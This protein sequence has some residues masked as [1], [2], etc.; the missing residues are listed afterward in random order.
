MKAKQAAQKLQA[1][2]EDGDTILA[3]INP[4]E[5]AHLKAMGGSG[6]VNPK[7]GLLSFGGYEGEG[8]DF[9]DV[10]F[11]GGDWGDAGLQAGAM[12]QDIAAQNFVNSLMQ[13][14]DEQKATAAQAMLS[15][16]QLGMVNNIAKG[17]GS[18]F[19]GMPGSVVAGSLNPG[20]MLND[21][22]GRE[23]VGTSVDMTAGDSLP[24]GG[25]GYDN[26]NG[27]EPVTAA[28]SPATSAALVDSYA[29][30][31]ALQRPFTNKFGLLRDQLST[32]FT[33][34]TGNGLLSRGGGFFGS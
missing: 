20:Q 33:R 9:G 13:Q 1:M 26:G 12:A 19:G 10:G 32:P 16:G 31:Q 15:Q 14:V 21:Y 24:G 34:S 5:A 22:L 29:T 23:R 27:V 28:A 25:I 7:T 30:S 11:S 4:G 2:G 6:K 3:H 17:F 8:T 18:L